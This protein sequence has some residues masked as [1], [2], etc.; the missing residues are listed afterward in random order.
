VPR[1]WDIREHFAH[2][3]AGGPRDGATKAGQGVA[4]PIGADDLFVFPVVNVVWR[5]GRD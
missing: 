2:G 3:A 5:F 1:F 4:V